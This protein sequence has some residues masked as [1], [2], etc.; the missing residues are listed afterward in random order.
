MA[1]K[2]ENTA[3]LMNNQGIKCLVYG[4]SGSGKT[5]LLSTAPR[6]IIF[7][8]ESG[9]LS[10]KKY[11]VAYHVI[12]TY[13]DLEEAFLWATKSAEMKQFD[14]LA[15]DSASEIAE[16]VLADLKTKNKDP[17]KA[18]GEVADTITEMFRAYRDLP[19]K[20]VVFLAK[21]ERII[22]TGTGMIYYGPMFP[23]KA[24]PLQIPYFFDEMFQ[25]CVFEDATSKQKQ[26]ALRTDKDFQNQAKDR[27]GCL[28]PWEP[29][30]LTHIFSKIVKG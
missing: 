30:D 1:F 7:S 12:N 27:S 11:Q 28:D 22:D 14:T 10:L 4:E 21:Q 9:L 18:Y 13:K 16:V 15:L 19:Q 26:R 5:R 3:N 2:I 8:A 25:L 29:A 24:L 6:P 23:G 17:R 20:N